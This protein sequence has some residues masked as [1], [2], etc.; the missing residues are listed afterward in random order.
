MA[1]N[2]DPGELVAV[3]SRLASHVRETG[4]AIP[5]GWVTPAGADPISVHYVPHLNTRTAALINGVLGSLGEVH[6]IAH[7]VGGSAV[8]YATTDDENA[9][10]I[11]RAG[12]DPV[13]NPVGG[14][15]QFTPREPP[16]GPSGSAEAVDSL[17]FARQ[18]RA[19]P[20]TGPAGRFA[21]A[22]RH[23]GR[24]LRMDTTGELDG[25]GKTLHNWTPVGTAAAE[26]LD[27]QRNWLSRLAGGFD[28]LA[29]GVDHY[30]SAFDTAKAKHPTPEEIIAT[31]KELV[32]AMRSKNEVRTQKALAEFQEQNARSSDAITGYSTAVGANAPVTSNSAMGATAAAAGGTGGGSPD[33]SM[34]SSLL[35]VLMSTL[36]SAAPLSQS[37][38]A[39]N[40]PTETGYDSYDGL[41]DY[42]DYA[43][44]GAPSVS[45]ISAPSDVSAGI[46]DVASSTAAPSTFNVAPMPSVTPVTGTPATAN[47]SF[48]QRASVIEPLSTASAQAAAQRSGQPMMPYMPMA[49]GMGG[50]G[51]TGDRN[52]VVAWHPDRLMYV[53]DTPHTEQVIGERPSIAPTVT[54]ATPNPAQAPSQSG[55]SA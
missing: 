49:P 17:T 7:H 50:A 31:R 36:A 13:T 35:P 23:F 53:D 4:T 19:G 12:G 41:P 16:A 26:S 28:E 37:L 29:D 3:A 54:P 40:D 39:A 10:S 9:R 44:S 21:D 8:D 48:A 25:A 38:N 27:R 47:S 33:M 55:G 20:G 18:L 46:P 14:V 15:L 11:G 34:L 6:S 30:R 22:L 45:D 1:L 2:V 42:A 51:G 32:A 52:R 43:D 24:G 5:K